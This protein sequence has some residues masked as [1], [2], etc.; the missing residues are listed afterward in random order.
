MRHHGHLTLLRVGGG[1]HARMNLSRSV[2]LVAWT[3][4]LLLFGLV[5][6][7]IDDRARGLL[8]GLQTTP[9]NRI[10]T[11]E[12]VV[13]TIVPG[14]EQRVHSVLDFVNK[15]AWIQTEVMEG[16]VATLVIV[17]GRVSM[18]VGQQLVPPMPGLFEEFIDLFSDVTSDPL[19]GIERASFDGEVSFGELVTG[20]GVSIEGES[21]LVGLDVSSR[22]Q[23]IFNGDGKLAAVLS[24]AEGMALL[25]VF[26]E[27][28]SGNTALAQGFVMYQVSGDS[29]EPLMQT[30]VESVTLNQAV[31]EALFN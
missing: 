20:F 28:F 15:R 9:E 14:F 17:D 3:L 19:E 4:A 5:Q 12:S 24:N 13:F 25:I 2:R 23:L 29:Y 11:L 16:L 22:A 7:Q 30:M 10:D 1:Y 6:A 27:P 31:D 21:A 26:D 18:R 8:E